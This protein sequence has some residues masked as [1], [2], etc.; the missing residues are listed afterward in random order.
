M[1]GIVG[2]EGGRKIEKG[3]G[4]EGSMEERKEGAWVLGRM[5]VYQMGFMSVET[6]KPAYL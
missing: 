3:R 5:F 1:E 4:M 6:G 2:K